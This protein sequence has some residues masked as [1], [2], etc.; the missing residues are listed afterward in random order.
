MKKILEF[1]R[2]T[3]LE[4]FRW[5]GVITGWIVQFVWFTRKTYYE[6]RK[7]R[8]RFVKGG[9]LVISNHYNVLD[10]I[11]NV[12]LFF[13]RKLHVIFADFGK[14]SR[15][16]MTFFGGIPVDR[17]SYHMPFMDESVRLLKK[18][19]VVQIYPE[20]SISKDGS[21]LPFKPSYIY[22]AL[23]AGVPI[24]PVIIDGNYG[25]FKRAHVI[26][27]KEIN[28]DGRVADPQHPTHGEIKEINLEIQAK[29]HELRRDLDERV[30]KRG[31]KKATAT[32]GE[33]K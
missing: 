1:F 3:F 23:R 26:V 13:P 11:C 28:L 31:R 19:K 16:G 5:F 22:I 21:M 30:A 24:I 8:G 20:A 12:F 15:I 9:A 32:E 17:S 10:Y 33:A 6:D 29:C 25:I 27:G 7:S 14:W 2:K 18:G 4:F